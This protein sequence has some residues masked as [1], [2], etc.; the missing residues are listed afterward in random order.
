MPNE[1]LPKKVFYGELQE[2]KRSQGG[3]KKRYQDTLKASTF[4]LSP[5]NRL[6]RIEQSGVA[7]STKELHSLKQRKSV[8]QKES[9]KNGKQEPMD[10]HHTQHSQTRSIC[11]RQFR[12]KFGLNTE[13]STN[14]Q[15]HMNTQYS[16]LTMVF[17]NN[18]RR[19]NH[20][21]HMH[22]NIFSNLY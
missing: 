15:S 4:R 20:E 1:R 9:A 16:G 12:A 10:H 8:K 6:H 2:G 22:V 17:I 3:Q 7:S 18:E 21:Y 5:G 14:T 19:S 11:N 13:P